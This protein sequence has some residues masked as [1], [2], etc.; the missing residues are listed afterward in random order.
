MAT[1]GSS[2]DRAVVAASHGQRLLGVQGQSP[3]LP[4]TVALQDQ[5]GLVSFSHNHLEYLAVLGPC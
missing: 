3:E 5:H 2:P 1:T 4:L